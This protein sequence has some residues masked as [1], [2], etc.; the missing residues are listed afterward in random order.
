MLK[1]FVGIGIL[2]TPASFMNVGIVGGVVGM[3]FIGCIATYT[4]MLQIAATMKVP[5]P[6]GNYSEL[7]MA[8]LGKKGQKFVD[9]CILLSQSGFAIAYLIFIGKQMDQVICF[10]TV[11]E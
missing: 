10:E 7:G 4:M 5:T 11:Y 6:V 8:V 9:F 1:V 3:V 2:A